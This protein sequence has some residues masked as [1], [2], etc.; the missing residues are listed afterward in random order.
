M[1]GLANFPRGPVSTRNFIRVLLVFVDPTS[2]NEKKLPGFEHEVY[3]CLDAHAQMSDARCLTSGS[4]R[5][6]CLDYRLTPSTT[7]T[8]DSLHFLDYAG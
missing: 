7:V 4:G 2:Q 5:I 3:S 6:Q 1:V 8:Y